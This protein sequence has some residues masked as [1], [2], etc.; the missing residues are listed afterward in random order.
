[1]E[2]IVNNN[3]LTAAEIR[4][5][6]QCRIYLQVVSIADITTGDGKNICTWALKGRKNYRQSR[7]DYDWPLWGEPSKTDWAAWRKAL[8]LTFCTSRATHLDRTLQ[9]WIVA[10]PSTWQWFVNCFS[11][12]LF[13]KEAD[14]T[15]K[16]YKL[17]GRRTR[18][19]RF[20]K[21]PSLTTQLPP[22]EMMMPTTVQ[23]YANHLQAQGTR[24]V[25]IRPDPSIL[26]SD[27]YKE[28]LE[29][30]LEST[31]S[32]SKIID[33]ITTGT[34]IAVSDGSYQ[35][36]SS[37]GAS[38]WTIES[39]DA[40]QWIKGTSISPG[41]PSIQNAYRSE[42]LGILGI[43]HHLQQLCNKHRLQQGS[44][45]VACDGLSALQ[46]ATRKDIDKL[47]CRNQQSDLLSSCTKIISTLPI[48]IQPEHVKGHQDD[49][50][51]YTLSRTERM[52]VSMD[53]L[54]K[55]TVE[56]FLQ[57][58]QP[59]QFRNAEP[60]PLAFIPPCIN[61][62]SIVENT[63]TALYKQITSKSLH[64]YWISQGRYSEDDIDHICWTPL[65]KAMQG[66]TLPRRRFISKW[67]SDNMATGTN[68]KR[69]KKRPHDYC[70]YC[71]QPKENIPHILQCTHPDA[72]INWKKHLLRYL[73]SLYKIGLSTS[74]L[75]PLKDE[76][77]I[78]K[79][80]QSTTTTYT[81]QHHRDYECD[82]LL[83]KQK[84]LGW[85]QFLEGLYI[86]EWKEYI[87][88]IC[89]ERYSTDKLLSKMIKLGWDF[90]FGIWDE[91]N[92]RLHQTDHIL[93]LEGRKELLLAM[94][95]E[96]RLG[97]SLLPASDYGYLFVKPLRYLQ[98]QSLD[99][100]KDWVATVKQ[101]R[102]LYQDHRRIDDD[103]NKQGPLRD[104]IGMSKTPL[105]EE[106]PITNLASN[107]N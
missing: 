34:A 91:R 27:L 5:A 84:T 23:Q 83:R 106:D 26:Q 92:Q 7:I 38:A 78:W 20:R 73:E 12:D 93:D 50:M 9:N 65:S 86:S 88:S 11:E 45:T 41:P 42:I 6:N 8:R 98:Q 96:W 63:K 102:E 104:W 16:T 39:A 36:S 58:N 14:G 74:L 37:V 30:S 68:M 44:I 53:F 10:L 89:P 25:S 57:H 15:W 17:L 55:A 54:A 1:M 40:T 103:F 100:Q 87:D 66:S 18:V 32:I 80:G 59:N 33:N 28:W 79:I 77:M 43:L 90:L 29:F 51:N 64:E 105:Y 31:T 82:Q 71:K 72:M 60:Y 19:N 70:P 95:Q 46:Q 69:W 76:L 24:P 21:I 35:S 48:T 3:I 52:N 81:P 56:F 101:G 22:L 4:K 75:L 13:E 99:W 47:S 94:E 97:L 61:G 67:I 62:R 2:E 49:I 107:N 85:N